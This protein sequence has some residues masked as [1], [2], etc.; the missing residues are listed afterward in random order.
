[1]DDRTKVVPQPTFPT[2]GSLMRVP[3]GMER[4]AKL[5]RLF[6]TVHYL[7]AHAQKRTTAFGYEAV[8]GGAGRDLGIDRNASSLDRIELVPRY[9][10]D[11]GTLDMSVDLFGK[12]YAAPFGVAPIGLPGIVMPGAEKYMAA[13]AKRA[14]VPYCAGTVAS[15]TVEELAKLAEDMLWF[16]LYRMP[17]NDHAHGFDLVRRAQSAGAQ[18]LCITMDVPIRTKRSREIRQGLV[19]PFKMQPHTIMDVLSSPAWL[20]DY[21]KHGLVRFANYA[22]YVDGAP[23]PAKLASYSNKDHAGGG[24]FSWEEVARYRDV[25]KGPLVAKGIMHPA[26]AE[27]AIAVGCNGVVVSNHGGRQLD[28][29]AASLDALPAVAR[30]V[31]SKMT[32]L[33][34]GGVR[35]GADI[36]KARALG[37]HAVLVGRATLYGVMAAGEA[38]AHRALEILSSEFERTMRL[39]GARSVAEIGSDLIA[40]TRNS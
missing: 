1:M 17:Q 11:K 4:Q 38:G 7:R 24:A 26:D 22:P 28:G 30:A 18:V 3:K 23:T 33:L 40:S 12:R 35:R 34:D 27:K 29:A 10:V 20:I 31:G 5:R 25:W 21:M 16:Q 9:G 13:A 36:L 37:A 14:G 15:N 6:P 19:L 2:G 39:C 8:D 32:V